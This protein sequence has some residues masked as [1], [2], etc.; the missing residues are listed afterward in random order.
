MSL[1]TPSLTQPL[2]S[3]SQARVQVRP[4]TI[5]GAALAVGVIAAFLV[6]PATVTTFALLA[7]PFVGLGA[8]V[9]F[10]AGQFGEDE[11]LLVGGGVV[12]W[13]RH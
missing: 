13:N 8:L 3:A 6:A 5:V 12:H 1:A 10:A 2:A 11:D 7:L 9:Q 4:T